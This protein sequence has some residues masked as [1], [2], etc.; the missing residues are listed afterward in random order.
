M[1]ISLYLW[2]ISLVIVNSLARGTVDTTLF[3][4]VALVVP[5]CVYFSPSAYVLTALFSNATMAVF[6]YYMVT[7]GAI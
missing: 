3:M 4:T 2:V 5:L 1:G 6:L 7:Q